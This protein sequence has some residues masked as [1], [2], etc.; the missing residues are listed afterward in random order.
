M[1]LNLSYNMTKKIDLI[2]RNCVSLAKIAQ[3]SKQIF[4]KIKR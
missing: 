1:V 3:G 2:E 4:E